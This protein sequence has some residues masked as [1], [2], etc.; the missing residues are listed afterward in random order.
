MYHCDYC[1]RDLSTSL[2]IKCAVCS[3]FD[4]CLECFSVGVEITP[5]SNDHAY[6]V[7]DN[8]SFPVYTPDWGADEEMLLL[9]GVELYG[10]GNWSKVAEYVGKAPDDCRSHYFTV[11]VE[12]ETF[13]VP[14]PAPEMATL[15][16]RKLIDERRRAGAERI[17]LAKQ[18]AKRGRPVGSAKGRIQDY[19]AAAQIKS[20]DEDDLDD[21]D[22]ED[23]KGGA[24]PPRGDK[25]G[26]KGTNGKVQSASTAT[27][28]AG[29]PAAD[30]ATPADPGMAGPGSSRPTSALPTAGGKSTPAGVDPANHV[31][32]S[33]AQQTGYH[34][35]RNEFDPEYDHEAEHIIAELDFPENEDEETV[36]KKLRLIDIYNRRLDERD[37]RKEFVLTRGL[38]NVKRQQ[39]LDRRRAP[40]EREMVGRLRMLA[41]YLPQAQWEA[42]ADGIA[43]EARLRARIAELQQYRAMGM[44]TFSEVERFEAIEGKKKK[45]A[46][47][48]AQQG[49]SRLQRIP[50]DETAMESELAELGMPHAAVGVHAQHSV[51]AEGRGPDGLQAWRTRRGVLLDVAALPDTGPL[52]E[53]ERSLCAMERFLPAQYLAVKAEAAKMQSEKGSV[54]RADVQGLPFLVDPDRSARLHTFFLEQGWISA[55]K[56]GKRKG[57]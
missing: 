14:K 8:L 45:E 49:K 38:V 23:S 37:R 5:H 7:V 53:N 31:M 6:R 21:E 34:L 52:T 54:S 10:L 36:A 25:G 56:E 3:D 51:A 44:R 9:E 40:S 11:Y 13:P 4:L 15:D 41:R 55:P 33:E 29:I 47:P 12:T 50:V 46:P 42:L 20:E 19:Y 39:A 30:V 16:I 48:A 22:I 35:K 28:P 43:T 24:P 17:A 57:A 2:R 26:A 32:L 27:T 18:A 1:Q